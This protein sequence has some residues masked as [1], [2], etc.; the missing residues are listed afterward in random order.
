MF[1]EKLRAIKEKLKEKI[2]EVAFSLYYSIGYLKNIGKNTRNY[3]L[4]SLLL[5]NSVVFPMMIPDVK[6]D[7]ARN[8]P[9]ETVNVIFPKENLEKKIQNAKGES[10]K[11]PSETK[12]YV[13]RIGNQP[14]SI[15][16]SPPGVSF[17]IYEDG[18]YC[19][20]VAPNNFNITAND[21]SFNIIWQNGNVKVPDIYPDGVSLAVRDLTSSQN[22]K[23]VTFNLKRT[24]GKLWKFLPYSLNQD[25]SFF[26]T[27][28]IKNLDQNLNPVHGDTGTVWYWARGPSASDELSLLNKQIVFDTTRFGKNIWLATDSLYETLHLGPS[29]AP[30]LFSVKDVQPKIT[31]QGSI[32]QRVITKNDSI[33]PWSFDRDYN[34][35][36][37]IYT[38]AGD[39]SL[40]SNGHLDNYPS[41]DTV[42]YGSVPLSPGNYPRKTVIT[43][44]N[45]LNPVFWDTLHVSSTGTSWAAKESL[46]ARKKPSSNTHG[47]ISS[48]GDFYVTI[49][50]TKNLWKFNG[51][52]WDSSHVS[53]PG[54]SSSGSAFT[55]AGN[56]LVYYTKDTRASQGKGIYVSED[57]GNS[58]QK[59]ADPTLQI[60]HSLKWPST[61]TYLYS[62]PTTGKATMLAGGIKT[63][64]K[65]GI[66]GTFDINANSWTWDSVFGLDRYVFKQGASGGSD[67]TGREYFTAGYTNEFF[68]KSPTGNVTELT[69]TAPIPSIKG[70]NYGAIA[71]TSEDWVYSTPGNNEKTF[72]VN[73]EPL[74]SSFQSSDT[75]PSTSRKRKPK[76][77]VIA[78]NPI[79]GKIYALTCNNTNAFWEYSPPYE[80]GYNY[81]TTLDQKVQES[82]Q[83][84]R[85]T[86][87]KDK[88]PYAMIDMNGN[89]RTNLQG[90]I[91]I[92]DIS[93]RQVGATE[94]EK[95]SNIA[96]ITTKNLE[97]GIYF[98]KS[99]NQTEKF[100][101]TGK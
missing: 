52:H 75:F 36:T 70:K 61:A 19:F 59:K 50:N 89:L 97:K 88:T 84:E 55:V 92:Y 68:T 21:G 43:P 100:V 94:V 8:V 82:V 67:A 80:K 16:V 72:S 35:T 37:T 96:N 58:W 22:N 57:N 11:L 87:I 28:N 78:Y 66:I 34:V 38:P 1:K 77:P 95:G 33:P 79:S 13:H 45:S 31:T 98:A 9:Q 46:P 85:I 30:H 23:G 25:T 60:G 18:F 10:D 41:Q 90:K 32:L 76:N 4:S 14:N 24:G 20:N 2:N 71:V 83:D 93:G 39:T 62:N 74:T 54:K 6:L 44:S 27:I 17:D 7:L 53:L 29:T 99:G 26:Y 49:G 91:E 47:A 3:A 51:T 86:P 81:T 69:A 40:T 63:A 15:T 65:K 42:Y 73:Y 101:V 56:E 48:T 5:A 12:G 64:S